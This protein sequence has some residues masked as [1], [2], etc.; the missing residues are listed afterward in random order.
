MPHRS[1][2]ES[3]ENVPFPGW[4]RT[5]GGHRLTQG[6]IE[7]LIAYLVKDLGGKPPTRPTYYLWRDKGWIPFPSGKR[8]PFNK[9]QALDTIFFVL[10][11]RAN[12]SGSMAEL[13]SDLGRRGLLPTDAPV[14]F[15]LFPHGSVR[16]EEFLQNPQLHLRSV[17][18]SG[19]SIV[20]LGSNS[21]PYVTIIS[22][23]AAKR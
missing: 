21:V 17:A 20:I 9:S 11:E 16:L 15:D 1:I 5:A 7:E 2:S 10:K 19:L 12:Y 3:S 22:V 18:E 6:K 4:E 8:K 23:A 14:Q 13:E